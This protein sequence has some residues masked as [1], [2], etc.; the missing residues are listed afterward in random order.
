M[1]LDVELAGKVRQRE[2]RVGT[3][4]PL[5]FLPVAKLLF[6]SVSGGIGVGEFVSY[7]QSYG[8]LLEERRT[9]LPAVGKAVSELKATETHSTLISW[10]AYHFCAY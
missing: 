7:S 2:E 1:V 5:L 4:E 6:P 8:S 10:Q 3:I 9:V